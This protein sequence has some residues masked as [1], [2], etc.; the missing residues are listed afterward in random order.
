MAILVKGKEGS[1]KLA[2]ELLNNKLVACSTNTVYGFLCR[3]QAKNA[4]RKIYVI[5]GRN[6][7]KQIPVLVPDAETI[8]Y[9][10]DI[11]PKNWKFVEK[12]I[13]LGH[14]VVVPIKI[15]FVNT[16][17]GYDSVAF[18]VPKGKL[19]DVLLKV[20]PCWATSVNHAG[21][22]PLNDSNKIEK[23][24]GSDIDMI[25]ELDEPAGKASTIVNFRYKKRGEVIR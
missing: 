25:C 19:N 24:F 13:S 10:C 11:K 21:Q 3:L 20:G 4:H 5:K 17:F 9:Y 14:T 18:R 22:P 1:E 16:F 15:Y 12:Q 23:F 8:K 2:E 7:L 6:I